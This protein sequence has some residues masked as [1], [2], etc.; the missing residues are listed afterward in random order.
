MNRIDESKTIHNDRTRSPNESKQPRG[1]LLGTLGPSW[2]GLGGFGAILGSSW[3]GV[4][5]HLGKTKRKIE[6]KNDQGQFE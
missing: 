3:D 6:N 2:D 5:R 1:E 4:S